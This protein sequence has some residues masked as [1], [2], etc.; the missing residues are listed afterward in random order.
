MSVDPEKKFADVTIPKITTQIT[1]GDRLLFDKYRWFFEDV[2][3]DEIRPGVFEY[4]FVFT[5]C[6]E[7]YNLGFDHGVFTG[8]YQ[9]IDF[10]NLF[11]NMMKSPDEIGQYEDGTRYA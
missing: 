2:D 10:R 8:K 3:A 11:V 6:N 5:F 7:V 4:K 1:I 9:C